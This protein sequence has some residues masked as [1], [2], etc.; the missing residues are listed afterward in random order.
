[1]EQLTGG[2][3]GGRASSRGGRGGSRNIRAAGGGRGARGGRQ[4]ENQGGSL[5]Q[6]HV[7]NSVNEAKVPENPLVQREQTREDNGSGRRGRGRGRGRG[8]RGNSDL[9]AEGT[10]P[11]TTG[12]SRRRRRGAPRQEEKDGE[13]AAVPQINYAGQ[14]ER[15]YEVCKTLVQS[16]NIDEAIA[17]LDLLISF[18]RNIAGTNF[19]HD[20]NFSPPPPP[21]TEETLTAVNTAARTGNGGIRGNPNIHQTIFSFLEELDGNDDNQEDNDGVLSANEFDF[22]TNTNPTPGARAGAP[23]GRGDPPSGPPNAN[24]S[25]PRKISLILIELLTYL[26]EL[27]AMK[28]GTI[29]RQHN[30]TWSQ[31]AEYFT[32]SCGF[33]GEALELTSTHIFY[34]FEVHDAANSDYDELIEMA[35]GL[36]I[37]TEHCEAKLTEFKQKAELR[38]QRVFERLNPQLRERDNIRDNVFGPER[39]T[40]NPNPRQDYAERRRLLEEEMRDLEAALHDLGVAENRYTEIHGQAEALADHTAL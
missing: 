13:D 10:G 30:V 25:S 2:N 6:H 29:R 1:M 32:K 36:S 37:A 11:R 15:A 22:R 38:R 19:N 33:L 4:Q 40:N 17:Y 35:H 14:W 9:P 7:D 8:G 21:L 20:I 26:G 28:A 18:L 16:E 31:G 23:N 34:T 24:G 3:H 12:R 27:Y 39:W 5:R